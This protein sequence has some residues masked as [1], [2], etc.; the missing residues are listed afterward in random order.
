MKIDRTIPFY[1]IIMKWEGDKRPRAALPRGYRFVHY[2]PGDFCSWY[3]IQRSVGEFEGEE[4]GQAEAYF[5]KTYG[6]DPARL[7]ECC[8][9][10][11]S[12]TGKK[13]GAIT[14]WRELD[15]RQTP[16]LHWLA[17]RPEAQG[18]GIGLAL[19]CRAQSLFKE[20]G[21]LPVYLHTQPWSYAAIRL[22]LKSGFR[23][24]REE[25]FAHYK[26]DWPQAKAVLEKY[27]GPEWLDRR[28]P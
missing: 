26:N 8:I 22:Y 4:P 5:L 7:R 15:Q 20:R 9:F 17:V 27:L 14:A 21:E 12:E 13:A 2:R 6:S 24:C 19:I 1:N 18:M 3:E 25:T 11:E 16:S 10:A 23:F 28:R